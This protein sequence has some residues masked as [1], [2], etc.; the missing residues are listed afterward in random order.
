METKLFDSELKIMNLLWEHGALK[1]QE[2]AKLLAAETGWSKTT[3]YTLLKRCIDKGLIA[4]EEPDFVC[5]PLISLE[6]V[7]ER[8]TAELIDKL[9]GGSPD[10]LMISLLSRKALSP[11]Q[12]EKLKSL[13]NRLK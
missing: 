9:Y 4:R 7:Q 12:V 13:V 8:E 2:L 11:Q 10:L 5:S 1:A 3:T 6:D